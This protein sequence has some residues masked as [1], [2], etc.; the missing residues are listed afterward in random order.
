MIIID[1]QTPMEQEFT[2][3]IRRQALIDSNKELLSY[4]A[5]TN[6]NQIKWWY[7]QAIENNIERMKLYN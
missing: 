2:N 1:T 5:S 7:N 3:K 4:Q 6:L